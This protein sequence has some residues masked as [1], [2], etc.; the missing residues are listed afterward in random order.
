MTGASRPGR[1]PCFA[2]SAASA[3]VYSGADPRRS[4][5]RPSS[6]VLHGQIAHG[7]DV[8]A[9]ES[10]LQVVDH[11]LQSVDHFI[12]AIMLVYVRLKNLGLRIRPSL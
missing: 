9:A 11:M 4:V 10:T 7:L 6:P 5:L 12:S 8:A 2:E 3:S 1:H